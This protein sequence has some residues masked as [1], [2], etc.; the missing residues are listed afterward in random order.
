MQDRGCD[1][2]FAASLDLLLESQL[3]TILI[4]P[5]RIARTFGQKLETTY[6]R[7]NLPS[8]WNSLNSAMRLAK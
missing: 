4:F 1:K 2:G 5:G 6:S 8:R 3:Q 7:F